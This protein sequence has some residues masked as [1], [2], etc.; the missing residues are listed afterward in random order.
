[1]F[2]SGS[3]YRFKDFLLCSCFLFVCLFV[4]INGHVVCCTE[5]LCVYCAVYSV[6]IIFVLWCLHRN[7]ALSIRDWFIC[8]AI[9]F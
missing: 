2:K 5:L 3:R 8:V 6:D 4:F 9:H 7:K 1:M